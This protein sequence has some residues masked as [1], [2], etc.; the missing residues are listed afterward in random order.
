MP[1]S[2]AG[3]PL[4]AMARPESYKSAALALAG[5]CRMQLVQGA[6]RQTHTMRM[7]GSCAA[8]GAGPEAVAHFLRLRLLKH[9]LCTHQARRLAASVSLASLS[10]CSSA[11]AIDGGNRLRGRFGWGG[12]SPALDAPPAARVGV[13]Q[14]ST[15]DSES[16]PYS[17][18]PVHLRFCARFTIQSSTC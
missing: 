16:T 7:R 12:V 10:A 14:Y 17:L 8:R 6:R 15:F 4:L 3:V 1:S 2:C 9:T 18:R 13:L 5:S 11:S